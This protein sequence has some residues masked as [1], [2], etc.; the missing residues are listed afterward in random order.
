MSF[1]N[2]YTYDKTKSSAASVCLSARDEL[3]NYI[4]ILVVVLWS[5]FDHNFKF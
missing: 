4:Y 1:P 5:K 3:E 2:I